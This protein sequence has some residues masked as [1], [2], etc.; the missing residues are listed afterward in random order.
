MGMPFVRTCRSS[1]DEYG[2][3]THPSDN[4]FYR[5]RFQLGPEKEKEKKKTALHVPRCDVVTTWP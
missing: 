5:S 3:H 2:V 4:G 1:V